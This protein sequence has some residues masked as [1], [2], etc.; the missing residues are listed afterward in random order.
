[1]SRIRNAVLDTEQEIR[2]HQHTGERRSEAGIEA[3]QALRRLILRTDE[4]LQLIARERAAEQQQTHARDERAC[5]VIVGRVLRFGLA[6]EEHRSV[7][8]IDDLSGDGLCQR[9]VALELGGAD[10]ELAVTERE[11]TLVAKARLDLVL[12]DA[13]AGT[14][15]IVDRM[16]VLLRRQAYQGHLSLCARPGKGSAD[17]HEGAE[18]ERTQGH[19]RAHRPIH[20]ALPS[21][22]RL[23]TLPLSSVVNTG[24]ASR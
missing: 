11:Q 8:R 6:A 23:S 13:D 14:E 4:S 9:L 18:G 5:A 12:I 2:S 17:G 16:L 1:M 3:M 21:Y 19:R 10:R 7:L 22:A 15:D 20:R 24:T